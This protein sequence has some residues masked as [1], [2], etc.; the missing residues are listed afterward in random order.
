[1]NTGLSYNATILDWYSV[2]DHIGKCNPDS[3]QTGTLSLTS[4]ATWAN[5]YQA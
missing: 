1:M 2:S 4:M 5:A 3:S